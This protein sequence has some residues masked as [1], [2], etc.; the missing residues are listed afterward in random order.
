MTGALL[1]L[2]AVAATSTGP[3]SARAVEEAPSTQDPPNVVVVLV[4]DGRLDDLAAM[5]R[6]QAGIGDAGATFSRFYA[7]FPLCCPAR[8][9]LLTGQYAHN[10][11]VLSNKAPTGGFSTFDDDPTLATWL[12]PTHRTGFIG[13]YLN[14][15]PPHYRPPGW[16]EW[17]APR[18][19]HSFT[20]PRWF[21]HQG[22]SGTNLDLPGYQTDTMAALAADFIARN[23][24]G[25]E[26]FFLLTALVAPHDG[27]PRD[28]DDVVGFPSPYVKPDYRDRYAHATNT[29]PSFDEAD[30][31]DKPIR[32]PPLTPQQILGITEHLQQR[33]EAS[34]SVDDAVATVLTA[35]A[36]SGELDQTYVVF[37]S[38]NG[39]M[40]GEHRIPGGKTAPYEVANHVPFLVRGPGINPGTVVPDVAAQV[41]LVPTVL[42]AAGLPV[43]A[44]VDGI[45]LRPL[46]DAPGSSTRAGVLLEATA[47]KSQTVPPPWLYQGV[48]DGRWKYVDRTKATSPDELYDLETDPYELTNVWSSP[49]TAEV[50]DRLASLLASYRT[51]AGSSCR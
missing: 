11:G 4:D 35:L 36:D 2:G 27:L 13:K 3:T 15:N 25:S 34:L 45:D 31:S 32:P 48:V 42:A 5:P 23:A 17:M 16:D 21:L 46:I 29:D 37:T 19:V 24:P 10:H 18:Q 39:L 22:V 20:N 41:D 43:P 38:D 33:L 7:P 9:T 6:T 49:E 51:C 28:P 1:T 26:P 50:R 40:L 12:T 14:G 30:V 8:A 47:V 44:S